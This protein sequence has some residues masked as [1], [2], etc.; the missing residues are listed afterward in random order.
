MTEQEFLERVSARLGRRSPA[1][2]GR[3]EWKP[4]APMP[5]VGPTERDALVDR[6]VL[7]AEKLSTRVYRIATA[8]EVAPMVTAILAEA[9][10]TGT[11]VRWDDPSLDGFGLDEAVSSAGHQVVPFRHGAESRQMTA[12]AERA[13]AGITGVD[14]AIA[15]TGS[16]VLASSRIGDPQAPGRGR[17]VSLLPPVH[18]ALVRKEQIIYSALTVFRRLAEGPLPSQVIFASG[19]SRSADIENDLSIGVH[20]PKQVHVIIL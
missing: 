17:T 11:V 2:A 9:A 10:A 13:V 4:S 12:L 19:P 14:A 18:I 15:E 16:L 20:G 7:E 6:F 8:A 5:D 3:P 1:E